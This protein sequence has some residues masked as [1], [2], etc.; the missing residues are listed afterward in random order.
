MRV[1]QKLV[2]KTRSMGLTIRRLLGTFRKFLIPQGGQFLSWV[3]LDFHRLRSGH[4]V[5]EERETAFA[6][7]LTVKRCTYDLY[8]K[9]Q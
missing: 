7:G 5:S 6:V 2:Q 1:S 8:P 3:K 9:G 4:Q